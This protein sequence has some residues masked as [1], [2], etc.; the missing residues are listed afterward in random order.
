MRD[1]FTKLLIALSK[2]AV[3]VGGAA[4][5][6]L[7]IVGYAFAST[8]IHP[9]G[10]TAVAAVGPITE[11]VDVS[12]SVKAAQS[13]DLAFQVS[14]RIASINVAVGQHV[15]AGQVLLALGSASQ[16]A[17]VAG[18]QAALEVQKAKLASLESGTRPEQLA[19]DQTNVAQAQST[20]LNSLQNAYVA[21]DDAV[22]VKADQVFTNPRSASAQIAFPVSDATLLNKVQSERVALESVFGAWQTTLSGAEADPVGASGAVT[23]DLTEVS[24]FLDDLAA[25]LAETPVGGS[26]TATALAGYQSSV[27]A[28]RS[29]I[30]GSVTGALPGVTTALTSYKGAVGALTLAQA[31]ATPEDLAAQQ[32]A[33]DAAAAA[34]QSA[35]ASLSDTVLVAPVSGTITAQNANPG[36]TATPGVPLV[37]MVAD[38]KYQATAQVSETDVAKIRVGDEVDA[39]VS[40]YPGASFPA[41]VTTVAPS[42]TT[43]DGVSGYAVTVT[44]DTVDPRLSEGLSAT[45]RIITA[46]KDSALQVPSSAIITNGTSTFVYVKSA[47]GAV[48]TPVVTGITSADGHT[49]IVSGLSAGD[50]VFSYGA[51]A[52][53]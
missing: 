4:V 36:E 3:A 27:N 35:Q 48:K 2:P 28:A 1:A 33:V 52:A 20:L 14:G 26:V 37:S 51:S 50:M 44:F 10:G 29:E 21:A 53:Q 38:G 5:I 25:L 39:T 32:A 42:V 24:A 43:V 8:A 47:G 15:A 11:E 9:T 46:T 22:H 17:A 18:A 16:S 7:A 40:A 6:G 49:E 19:I 31:G 12:A 45:L 41:K 23:A 13:T 30:S 34:V